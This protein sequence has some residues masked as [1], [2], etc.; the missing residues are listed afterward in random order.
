MNFSP[1]Y[2]IAG[3]FLIRAIF[4]CIALAVGDLIEWKI[5]LVITF[6]QISLIDVKTCE[7]LS[8]TNFVR[9]S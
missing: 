7:C 4:V 5:S 6:K 8:L 3:Y 2:A 9:L 1:N